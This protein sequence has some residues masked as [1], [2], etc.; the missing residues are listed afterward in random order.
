MSASSEVALWFNGLTRRQPHLL[1]G[2]PYVCLAALLW[3]CL[4]RRGNVATERRHGTAHRCGQS[5]V[6]G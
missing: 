1:E 2:R 3:E 6:L 4:K 5:L